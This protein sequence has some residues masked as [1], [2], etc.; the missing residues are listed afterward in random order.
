M[1]YYPQKGDSVS[2]TIN[3]MYLHKNTQITSASSQKGSH[4]TGFFLFALCPRPLH[5]QLVLKIAGGEG[6]RIDGI[7]KTENMKSY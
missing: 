2:L 3:V 5:V 7:F 6:A 1:K 4:V